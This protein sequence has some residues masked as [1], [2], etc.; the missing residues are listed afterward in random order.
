[1]PTNYE[2]YKIFTKVERC[3]GFGKRV[4]QLIAG[5]VSVTLIIF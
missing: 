4:S 1:M 3:T 2:L 5:K